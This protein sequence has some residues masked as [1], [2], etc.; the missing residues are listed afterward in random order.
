MLIDANDFLFL[1]NNGVLGRIDFA[2]GVCKISSWN[3]I[4]T[5]PRQAREALSDVLGLQ[6]F[7]IHQFPSN[8]RKSANG[9]RVYQVPGW[10]E[11][12]KRPQE[13]LRGFIQAR[14]N[15][16][17]QFLS[18]CEECIQRGFANRHSGKLSLEGLP[19]VLQARL[20][21]FVRWTIVTQN[22]CQKCFVK[23]FVDPFIRE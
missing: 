5:M 23:S 19:Y 16:R 7:Q 21:E 11:R 3:Q 14:T 10:S 20:Q 18:R 9:W 6:S 22:V 8:C 15:L 13:E 4:K 17:N 12:M 1:I 2:D